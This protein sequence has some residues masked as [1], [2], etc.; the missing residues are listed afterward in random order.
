MFGQLIEPVRA[1]LHK[2]QHNVARIT[3]PTPKGSRFMAMIE[4]DLRMTLA[5]NFA[6][7]RLWSDLSKFN[8]VTIAVLHFLIAARKLC[9]PAR[10]VFAMLRRARERAFSAFA[11]TNES[12]R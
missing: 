2:A 1:I 8:A 9:L 3:K 5:A 7:F 6:A 12:W 10:I 11:I 4:D